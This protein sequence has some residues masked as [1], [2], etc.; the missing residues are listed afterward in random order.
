MQE[1]DGQILFDHQ[2]FV[3]LFQQ[4]LP[5]SSGAV[6]RNETPNDQPSEPPPPGVLPSIEALNN[7][8][9]VP[10]RPGALLTAET[11]PEQ[12]L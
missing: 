12:P 3:G 5:S 9:L 8:P 10:L 11:S 7:H 2:R 6:S 1:S 4:H